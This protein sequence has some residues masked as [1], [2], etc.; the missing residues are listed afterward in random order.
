MLVQI[1]TSARDQLAR[2]SDLGVIWRKNDENE[3]KAM[4][5]EQWAPLAS[6]FPRKYS[7]IRSTIYGIMCLSKRSNQELEYMQII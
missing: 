3:A 5:Y 1:S 4:M 6:D 2:S 7:G